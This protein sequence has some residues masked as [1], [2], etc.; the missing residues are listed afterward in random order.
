[1][2]RPTINDDTVPRVHA[3]RAGIDDQVFRVAL[4]E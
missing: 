4:D 2:L 3:P 1:M